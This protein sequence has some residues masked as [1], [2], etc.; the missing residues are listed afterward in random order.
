MDIFRKQTSERVAKGYDKTIYLPVGVTI[1]T[2]GVAAKIYSTGVD[3]TATV[4]HSSNIITGNKS[5]QALMKDGADGQDY[6]ITF[7]LTLS[8]GQIWEEELLMEVRNV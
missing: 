2:L 8:D 7:T 3:A 6:L 1:S 4:V 5:V